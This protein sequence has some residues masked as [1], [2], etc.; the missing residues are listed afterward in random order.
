MKTVKLIVF[1]YLLL[2]MWYTLHEFINFYVI[3]QL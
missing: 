1:K 2:Y 3:E